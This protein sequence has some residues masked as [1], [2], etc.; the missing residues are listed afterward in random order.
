MILII[1]CNLNLTLDFSYLLLQ[2]CTFLTHINIGHIIR[3]ILLFI[4]YG[5]ILVC[6]SVV[7]WNVNIVFSNVGNNKRI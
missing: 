6:D 5:I 4:V 7:A 2:T 3:H 1:R